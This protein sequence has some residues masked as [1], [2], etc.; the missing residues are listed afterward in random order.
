MSNRL[1]DSLSPYLKQHAE[2]PVHWQE[3]GPAAFAEARERDVPILLSV[4]YAACHWCHVMAHQSFSDEQVAAAVNAAFVAVKV[5]REERP[6]VDAVYMQATQ[7]M[8]GQG[9]W[10][11]TCFLTPAGDPF[12]CGTYYP[13]PQFLQLLEAVERVWR[14]ERDQVAGSAEQITARL[15]SAQRLTAGSPADAS[16]LTGAVDTLAEGFDARRGGFG[17]APKFPPSMVL[18]FLL[19]HHG[20]TGSP[21]AL[22]MVERTC[23]AMACGGIYDQLAGGFARYS[24]DGDWVVPHFEKMLYDNALLLRAYTRW[25]RATGSALA[26]RV[27]VETAEFLLRDLRTPE[28]G[29]ASSLDADADGV[30]GSTYVW[31]PGQLAEVLG[32]ADGARAA[33]LLGVTPEGTFE[34][35]TSTLRMLEDPPPEWP[36]WRSALLA[37]RGE[38]VQPALDDKVVTSWNGLVIA[39]LAEAGVLLGQPEWVAAARSAAELLWELHADDGAAGVR[40]YRSSRRGTAGEAAG[41]ADDYGNLAGGLLALHQATGEGVWLVRAGAL[42]EVALAQFATGDGAFYD[43]PADGEQLVVRM[44]GSTDNAEPCGT[45]ALAE[46]L[47]TYAALTGEHREAADAAIGAGMAVARIDPRFAGWTLAAAEAS[48]AGPLQVA[49]VGSDAVAEEMVQVVREATSPGLVLAAGPGDGTVAGD[50]GPHPL[51]ADRPL[52]DGGSA[53][54]VCRGFVCDLPMTTVAAL[55]EALR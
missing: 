46:A 24:V 37:V 18:E 43:T 16:T 33:E 42:L 27:V 32:P 4:G 44:R 8:T 31:T 40:L 52:V 23:T 25:Y 6:D 47:G 55:H 22:E 9:G 19:R 50:G 35:G 10:P 11:M 34:A 5:D 2:N 30:E 21:A 48:L 7:A 14:T 53:A 13:K 1:K 3:W 12:F 51:L 39:A 17:D 45:S 28:G 36:A 20:R 38:R 54:Y 41:V 15:R 26:R 29:F 49:V